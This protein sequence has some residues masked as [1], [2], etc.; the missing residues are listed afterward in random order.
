[1]KKIKLFDYQEDMVK[2]VQEAFKHHDAVMVQMPTGTGKTMVLANIVFSFLEK[3]NHPIWIVAHRRELVEQI[4]GT[5]NKSLLIFS[6]H[7]V[8]LSKEGLSKITPSLFTIKEGDFS[9]THP[10]SLTLKGGSTAFPKPLSPQGTG[11][12]TAPPRCS[13]PLRSKDGGPS[14]VSPDCAGWDRLAEKEDGT[15]SNLIEKPLDSS[16]FTLR[17][18]LIKVMSIQWL[19][20]HYGEMEEKPGLIVID[21]AHHAL[22]ETY[23]EVMNAYPK[24][25]KLGLTATPYR[26]NGKGFTDLFDTLLC[27][28]SMEKF[29]AEGRLSLYDYYS[30]KPDSADQLLIDSLQKRG[31]DGDYQQKELNEVMDV[32]PSLERL[33]LTIKEYVPGKKGIVYAISIQHAEHIA[34]FYRENGI[35]AVAISSKT[36]S[37]LR[38]ELIERFKASSFSSFSEKTVESSKITPSLFTLKEGSTSHPDPLTLRGEGGNRPTRCSEPLRSKDGGPSKVSPGCAGWDRLGATCLRAGDGEIEVLVS[39]DLFSEGFDCPDVEFIQLARPTL[40]LA[41]YMQ[42]VGRGLRVAEGKEYCVILDNVGLYKRFGLPSV[43]R[44]WQSMFEGR[45]SLED[46]LQEACMH[47]NSHNCRMDVLMDGDEEMMKIINHERQQQMIMDTYGYQIVEDEKGLKGIKDKDGK[48]ILECQYKKIEVTNDGFA[49]CYIRKKVGRKEWIDLRNRLWFANKPQ[50]VKLMGIDFCTEDGKKLY[51]R[52]LSKYI[53]EKTYLTVKTLELQV[54][55]GLSWKHRF[56][57]WDEQ[58]KVYMYK[59]GEGNSRLYIDENEQYYVQKNIGS[60]LEKVDSRE[61]LAEFAQKDKEEREEG[62]EKLKNSYKNYEYYPVGHLYPIKKYLGTAKDKITIEKDGIWHVEDAQANESFWVDPITHRKHYTR[63]VL[64]KRGYLNIIREGDWC[65]VR[66]IPGLM[67]RPLRQWEIVADDNICVINNKYLIEKSEPDQWYKICRRTDDFTYFSV[68]A[69]YYESEYIKDDTEI[70]IT[71]FD[72]EG[73]KMTQEG[74]TYTP[75][76]IKTY[77]RNRW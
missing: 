21:E 76:V 35:K 73:L 20:R 56:I 25:K 54:G 11:D 66:N 12:V 22:A 24:S 14:K 9:K 17:S 36:P 10:S 77:K 64:F 8:P 29:I 57:P 50:S 19:S 67:N 2:R 31:A 30:I 48:M 26:L 63:P 49:Y 68:L 74:F 1:M 72:G 59:E 52:I 7:P 18:S 53:D 32:K 13:E 6:N 37:S 3:C 46:I 61:E 58:N 62:L 71:Q 42:M 5:L 60:Q 75:L 27:S 38:E 45:T 16:L 28:W 40:S 47:V 39:V 41:K 51:P 69:C 15:S 4:K 43:D 55:T 65:Y 23:A 70:Q 33:C 34:E 44:D